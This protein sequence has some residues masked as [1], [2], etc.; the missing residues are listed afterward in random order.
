VTGRV[1]ACAQVGGPIT[2]VYHWE[3]RLEETQEWTV[4]FKAPA[5]GYAA[6]EAHIKEQHS[7][8]VPEILATPV[9]AANPDYANWVGSTT[10][11]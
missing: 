3:G 5:D 8:D 6:L 9:S 4:V 10:A 1:A 2:S 11:P 7:Y